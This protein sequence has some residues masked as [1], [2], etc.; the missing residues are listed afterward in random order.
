MGCAN[1]HLADN[2]VV[3]AVHQPYHCPKFHTMP[4]QSL[5]PCLANCHKHKSLRPPEPSLLNA[6]LVDTVDLGHKFFQP[7]LVKKHNRHA[8]NFP[9]VA[10]VR[11]SHDIDDHTAVDVHQKS[12]SFAPVSA[13]HVAAND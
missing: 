3:D 5:V 4:V 10:T 1:T 6:V 12:T 13:E 9:A 8:S 7:D 2:A 11:F